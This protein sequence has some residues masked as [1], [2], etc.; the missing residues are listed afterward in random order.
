MGLLER[1]GRPRRR[2]HSRTPVPTRL[3]VSRPSCT[4]RSPAHVLLDGP[5]W[6]RCSGRAPGQSPGSRR[7]ATSWG[8]N[9]LLRSRQRWTTTRRARPSSLLGARRLL[10]W[11][12]PR[13]G[14]EART[15]ASKRARCRLRPSTHR[16]E[17]WIGNRTRGG[18]DGFRGEHDRTWTL[19][20]PAARRQ[21]PL[22]ATALPT[23][24]RGQTPLDELQALAACCVEVDVAS[25]NWRVTAQAPSKRVGGFVDLDAGDRGK[26]LAFQRVRT[27]AASVGA[28]RRCS[29]ASTS[30]LGVVP[31]PR[32]VS[33]C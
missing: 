26:V 8:P 31:W 21:L 1:P 19:G 15:R 6:H 9:V 7:M 5:S 30:S 27:V 17:S 12:R 29:P 16:S 28:A 2:C 23:G 24:L 20:T 10:R 22:R 18:P 25:L 4:R 13:R 14:A 11:S 3:T 33:L 32:P